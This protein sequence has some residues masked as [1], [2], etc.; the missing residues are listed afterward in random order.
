MEWLDLCS[1]ESPQSAGS[2][3]RRMVESQDPSVNRRMARS[4]LRRIPTIRRIA[5]SI[6]EWW[7]GWILLEKAQKNPNPIPDGIGRAEESEAEN[8]CMLIERIL[9]NPS[10]FPEGILTKALKS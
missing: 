7:D 9:R 3:D 1:E 8:L 10:K 2:Q 6:N 5:G 4:M